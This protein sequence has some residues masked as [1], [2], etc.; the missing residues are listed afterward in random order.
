MALL[1]R[2]ARCS[3]CHVAGVGRRGFAST[4]RFTEA[5]LQELAKFDSHLASQARKA[6]DQNVAVEWRHLDNQCHPAYWQQAGGNRGAL[7]GTE[8]AT[9]P[10]KTSDSASANATAGGIGDYFKKFKTSVT[11]LIKGG[12]K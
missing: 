8:R 6:Q 5:Q 11:G 1:I 10:G 3:A 4:P 9:L 12:K 2:A 7:P